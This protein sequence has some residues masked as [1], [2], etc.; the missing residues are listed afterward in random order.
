MSFSADSIPP[1]AESNNSP[2]SIDAAGR[3]SESSAGEPAHR[4]GGES[5]MLP[6]SEAEPVL[7]AT[8]MRNGVRLDGEEAIAVG[9]A[10]CMALT[11]ALPQQRPDAGDKVEAGPPAVTTE[12]VLIDPGSRFGVSIPDPGDETAAIA[13]VARILL[14]IAPSDT[15]RVLRPV[16]AK[17]LASPPQF[18]TVAELSTAFAPFEQP[19]ERELIQAVYG[20]WNEVRLTTALRSRTWPA[21]E[22]KPTRI[23]FG[24]QPR[25]VAAA[26]IVVAL[27]FTG[28]AATFLLRLSV[29]GAG[30]PETPLLPSRSMAWV[31]LAPARSRVAFERPNVVVEQPAALSVQ[32]APVARTEP[33]KPTARSGAVA[34]ARVE[35]IAPA[36]PSRSSARVTPSVARPAVP[37]RTENVT[38]NSPPASESGI[39]QST[40]IG[41]TSGSA[42]V[43]TPPNPRP[44]SEPLKTQ[45]TDS[46]STR[47]VLERSI[48]SARDVEVVPPTPIL[49]RL[50]ASLHPSSPGIRLDAL[51]IA[52]VV[53]EQGR[54]Y[55]VNGVHPPQNMGEYV[56][57]T[58]A[59]A[60]VKSWEFEPASRDGVP[61]RYR[62]IVPLKAVTAPVQ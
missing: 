56:L 25:A 30:A 12:T 55:S 18:R 39:R 46:I 45:R 28:V 26:A 27:F 22:I 9:R 42:T 2:S 40:S 14:E 6:F 49:P 58:S 59:L 7:L 21:P 13:G 41:R 51:A 1:V 35:R 15:V 29:A 53:D 3:G 11:A 36:A 43:V 52:V 37:A 62:L 19:H 34:N 5:T 33:P 38:P 31:I 54:A 60:V 32:P 57:L 16:L 61:V 8:L 44:A 17:A 4:N 20:R 47:T 23:R 10:L 50:L 24:P 48:Y